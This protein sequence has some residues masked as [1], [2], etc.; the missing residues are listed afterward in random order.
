MLAMKLAE[1]PRAAKP[2]AAARRLLEIADATETSQRKIEYRAGTAR[3]KVDDVHPFASNLVSLCLD[4]YRP[5]AAVRV[6][7]Q[8]GATQVGDGQVAHRAP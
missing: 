3:L 4:R 1:D 7:C 8:W 2:E 6:E 5:W